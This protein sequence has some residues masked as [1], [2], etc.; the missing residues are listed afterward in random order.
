MASLTIP[1]AS[2]HKEI[3]APSI[4]S[5]NQMVRDAIPCFYKPTIVPFLT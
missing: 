4:E 3:D 1:V 5:V 2:L